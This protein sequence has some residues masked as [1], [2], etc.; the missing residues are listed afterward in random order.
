MSQIGMNEADRMANAIESRIKTIAQQVYKEVPNDKE[1]EGLVISKNSQNQYT[2]KINNATYTNIM[3]ERSLGEIKPNTI[4]KVKV[5]NNQM[6]NAY[7]CGVVDGTIS[8]YSEGGGAG[9]AVNVIDN[10][11]S[12]STTEALS[13]NQG[14]ILNNKIGENQTLINQNATNIEELS[15]ATING[16]LISNNPV[17]TAA[18]VGALPDTT[19]IPEAVKLY[20]ELGQNTDGAMTQK[21]VTDELNKKVDKVEGKSL[22]AD[23]EIVRLANV[24]N[25]DDTALSNRVGKNEEDIVD[26][27]NNKADKDALK[28]YVTNT[29][30]E[31]KNY[32]T[33][34]YVQENGG[35]I[36]KIKVNG[37]E[38]TITNK[39]VDIQ[40]DIVYNGTSNTESSVAEKE[41]VCENFVLEQGAIIDIEFTYGS[42]YTTTELQL[43]LNVNNTGAKRIVYK[44]SGAISNL[45]TINSDYDAG[46]WA[47]GN[48]MRFIYTGEYWT[49]LFNF[50]RN[51]HTIYW[52]ERSSYY[53]SAGYAQNVRPS[54]IST[55]TTIYPTF[56]DSY[57]SSSN[58]KLYTDNGIS[59][60]PSTNILTT[61]GGISTTNIT[62]SGNLTDGTNSI[63]VANIANANDIPKT[64]A[65]IGALPNTTKYAAK[66]SLSINNST[67][68][69][70]AQLKDQDGNNLGTAQTIDLPLESVVVS[71]SYDK[72][73]KEVILTLK[74]GST[75]KFS[76]ADL[77][78]GLATQV[79]LDNL[80]VR[81]ENLETRVSSIDTKISD[82][83][84]KNTQQDTNISNLAN[85]KVDKTT[86]V[87][88]KE[89]S[90]NITIS[91]GD[92]NVY[93]KT[94]TNTLLN[95]KASTEQLSELSDAVT[96]ISTSVGNNS[97]NIK[98][99]QSEVDN[100]VDKSTTI[101]GKELNSN[102]TLSA[103]DVG[104]TPENRYYLTDIVQ[105]FDTLAVY[106]GSGVDG[107]SIYKTIT[108]ATSTAGGLMSSADKSK[109]DGI[110]S[111][112]QVNVQTDWN[113]T[114]TTS[115]AYLKNK[116]D[117][118]EGS[119]L[120]PDLGQNTDGSVNQK[121]I[122]DSLKAY[123][124]FLAISNTNQTMADITATISGIYDFK[125]YEGLEIFVKF[126][127]GANFSDG[128]SRTLN[129]NSTGAKSIL[130]IAPQNWTYKF[131][132]NVSA[133]NIVRFVYNGSNWLIRELVTQ[134]IDVGA[135]F[136]WLN[137]I[138]LA[139]SSGTDRSFYG[140]EDIRLSDSYVDKFANQDIAGIKNFTSTPTVN[141]VNVATV[142]DVSSDITV[143]NA[144]SSTSENP[145]QNK[146]VNSALSNKL[147]L[148]G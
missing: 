19:V 83:E 74:D 45:T 139:Q 49:P 38:Q 23:T 27:Q 87:N 14:R 21:A 22:I 129:I 39:E 66:L 75:I 118:P 53:D 29:E 69:I 105:H 50:T 32:A 102:I 135:S 93:T 109:L 41:V 115:P 54:Y 101:N 64:A 96:N 68:V 86:T 117:I 132:T 123:K 6:N 108:A 100:K 12:T 4:V 25:Y 9:T 104:A 126:N 82:I 142:D 72:T 63:T 125:L 48:T 134:G 116:P 44:S 8:V 119:V 55:N 99:L 130:A 33:E 147:N 61:T 121:I 24:T 107:S 148:T 140:E 78:S 141:G 120:Y 20:N 60:N 52:T 90:G 42:Y 97:E 58:E 11:D 106:R 46:R 81:V 80:E 28:N 110:E 37:V 30:L 18:D 131:R 77:V 124:D 128:Q 113:E 103:S 31:N 89:L 138:K 62:V 17:L 73:T 84:T 10:L 36:D 15:S 5:P 7:I 127:N 2:I 1:V 35:K 136:K 92:L 65:D 43:S 57:N 144:L 98:D 146:V 34:T 137:A 59:Y 79:D 71:G 95:E 56:V 3:Q 133:G 26:L 91:A 114:D 70:T 76:V 112:A 16:K 145:V 47:D 40:V 122:T 143:D 51:I 88:G 111:G 67:Y 85:N 13:A 94:E